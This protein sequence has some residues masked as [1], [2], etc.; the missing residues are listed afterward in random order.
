METSDSEF[1]DLNGEDILLAADLREVS[2]SF[3]GHSSQS[4][5]KSGIATSKPRGSEDAIMLS[6]SQVSQSLFI[7]QAAEREDDGE[8][9]AED[10]IEPPETPDKKKR[11]L[12]AHVPKH[13]TLYE[14]A[15]RTQISRS[16]ESPYRIRGPIWQKQTVRTPGKRPS[17]ERSPSVDVNDTSI[18]QDQN[19]SALNI[20]SDGLAGH[21]QR[22]AI[23]PGSP[24]LFNISDEE[25]L[26]KILDISSQQ[27]YE[28]RWEEEAPD[29][30]LAG[31]QKNLKQ[32]T[33]FGTQSADTINAKSQ[34]NRK[35]NWPLANKQEKP[36]HHKL[37]GD[38]LTTW[39]YPMNVGTI[40][41]YQFNIVAR[42]LY[43]NLLV[44]LPT[45]L[46]KTFIAATIMLNWFRWTRDA[47][48]V[49]VAPTKP[50]VS[51]QV[52][53]CFHIA[54]IPRSAT[55]MLTG[56]ISPG[57]RAEEWITKRVFF[58]TPQTLINDL[59]TGICDPKRIVLLVVDEAHRA[60]GGYAYVEVVS[61]LRRFNT[62]FRVLALTATPGS[63]VES[64]QAVIDGLGISRVEIR[65][66]E[67]LDIRQYV[68]QRNIMTMEFEPSDEM[69]WI[70]DNLSKAL[71]PLVDLM[72][73]KNAYWSKDPMTL[74]AYGCNQARQKWM[75]SD[76]GR[77][78]SV[79]EK[80]QVMWVFSALASIAHSIDLLKYHGIVPFYHKVKA[81][82]EEDKGGKFAKQVRDNQNFN[83]I[84]T[85]LRIWVTRPDFIGHPKLDHLQGVVLEHFV[86][87]SEGRHADPDISPNKT[88]VMIFAHFRDSAEEIV[89]VLNRNDPMIRAHVFVGQASAAG[90]DGM[91][92]KKQ[93]EIIEQFRKGIYNTLVATSIG[94]E[95]LD[96]GEVDLI[97]C[98]DA[99]AS[100]IRMLQRM[101]RT[102]RKRAGEIVVLLMKGKE[103]NNFS[104]AKDNYEKMQRMIADGQTFTFHTDLSPR[105]IP[106][107]LQPVVDKRIVEIPIENSQSAL[108]EPK[109]RGR[110][111]KRP[112][113]KFNMPD[114]VRTGFV[115]A[116]RLD[117]NDEE[118][119]IVPKSI[120]K[121][122]ISKKKEKSTRH[123]SPVPVPSLAS[124]LLSKAEEDELERNYL[125]IAGDDAEIVETP[126]LDAFPALQRHPRP[127]VSVKHGVASE[128][129]LKM[130]KT[131]NQTTTSSIQK[132]Q[133]NLDPEDTKIS[134]TRK[135]RETS[136]KSGIDEPTSKRAKKNT[137]LTHPPPLLDQPIHEPFWVSPEQPPA[138]IEASQDLP[139]LDAVLG[140]TPKAIDTI[141]R[142]SARRKRVVIDSDSDE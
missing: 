86:S 133:D 55:T 139:D 27:D 109:K 132:L 10:D 12:K 45:G 89:R 136:S 64:V 74:T 30:R 51:Q 128:R 15:F 28:G 11:K 22:S 123:E 1:G 116:S 76:A 32:T 8:N 18:L 29:A 131:M 78:S 58:M 115:T 52:D 59:K 34:S 90:S 13:D 62:S 17:T 46:G 69:I 23:R 126:R 16:S 113:K 70:F 97:V 41:E 105:I 138:S 106:R 120:K 33:L 71:Q 112:P 114:G 127:T 49:F 9:D 141:P 119:E 42:G 68:H 129:M 6:S 99:S 92:Q 40:R 24:D 108:P 124:V 95:G 72:R 93:L 39:I 14:D 66:E 142:K 47:Q 84:L 73:S 111:P 135:S 100:P 4:I 104:A 79:G 53:A 107:E 96:I 102:G 80:G 65:T 2:T 61:F 60:T 44:A 63:S 36:T 110:P 130:L 43:H 98:Y 19:E 137:T 3:T 121:T 134:T 57:L 94:E 50:L 87:A 5:G 38:E 20:L 37:V 81:F 25:G 125:Q 85:K 91:N 83:D 21:N 54:G 118:E 117:D 67:S 77:R 48:I 122:P 7:S 31:P 103:A 75:S 101:G 82:K 35:H 26:G 88:R 140:R 56:G